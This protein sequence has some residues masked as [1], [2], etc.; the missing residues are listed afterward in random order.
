M[1]EVN[2]LISGYGSGQVLNQA[3]LELTKGEVVAVLGRNGVGKTTFLKTLMC[4]IAPQS[5][6]IRFQET[7]LFGRSTHDIARLGLGYVPQGRGI[8][9]KLTVEENLQM[10]L[11]A[12]E[13]G[14]GQIPSFIYERFPILHERRGQF[15]GTLSGGQKQ[16]LAISRALCGDPAVLL[17]DEPSEGIQPNIVQEIGDFVRELA[18]DQGIATVLV[19]QNLELINIAC[20]RFEIME[21]G[22][23][24]HRGEKAELKDEAM[25]K[26]YLAV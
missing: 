14:L 2:E 4:I 3:S 6:S 17:L 18:E 16:Q 19:E 15:A 12:R 20:D 5:G 23:F 10:G 13:D 24:V 22:V 8:F 11:R 9:D 26:K 21:K 7:E 25:L 1:L